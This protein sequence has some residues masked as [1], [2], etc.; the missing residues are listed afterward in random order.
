MIQGLYETHIN[1]SDLER[2]IAF[3]RDLLGLELAHR[4]E[5]RRVAFFWM[6]QRGQSMLGLWEKPRDQ[7]AAQHFAFRASIDDVVNNSVAWLNERGLACYNFLNDGTQRPMVFGWM[8]AVSI[9]FDDPDGHT[10]ELIAILSGKPRPEV[11]VI[12]YDEWQKL[13]TREMK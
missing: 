10:L 3:Y 9:Y 7:I 12:S 2:S 5:A 6:G 1:V 8:P 11:G 4:E 13:N